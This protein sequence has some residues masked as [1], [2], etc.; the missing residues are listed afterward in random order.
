M[1]GVC[2]ACKADFHLKS[3]RLGAIESHSKG[4]K[5]KSRIQSSTAPSIRNFFSL[6]NQESAK[7]SATQSAIASTSTDNPLSLAYNSSDS[8]V[9]PT[10]PALPNKPIAESL[11][12]ESVLRFEI[13]WALYVSA[14]HQ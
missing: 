7:S 12:Q 2:L 14:S 9:S 13:F 1:H 8:L 6:P 5:H 10:V 11:T 4:A 3:I